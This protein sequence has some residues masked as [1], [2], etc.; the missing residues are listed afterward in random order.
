MGF[1]TNRKVFEV[2]SHQVTRGR[3]KGR[4]RWRISLRCKKDEGGL[5]L[6]PPPWVVDSFETEEEALANG[7]ELCSK[8]YIL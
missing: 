2:K 7:R 3:D 8:G 6:T 5:F 1:F 4:W